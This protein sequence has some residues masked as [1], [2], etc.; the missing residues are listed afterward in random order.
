[1]HLVFVKVLAIASFLLALIFLIPNCL[2]QIQFY[3]IDVDLD[4]SGRSFVTLTITFAEIKDK[5]D[6]EVIG[7]VENL[8]ASSEFGTINCTSSGKGVSRISCDINISVG[9]TVKI[10][11]ETNDFVKVLE[12][13]YYFD[14][15]FT[16][17]QDIDRVSA[18]A[19]LP[20]GMALIEENL[21]ASRVSFPENA[22][23]SASGRRIIVIWRLEEIKANQPLKLQFLYEQIAEVQPISL[24]YFVILGVVIALVLIVAYIRFFKKPQKLVLSVLDE[25][26]RKVMD[27]IIASGGVINQKKVVEQTN[28]SKAKVSRVVK[29]LVERGLIEVESVGR[30]NKLK[31]VKKKLSF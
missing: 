3:G 4:R 17:G 7:R 28:L 27:A 21:S 22:S 18:F 6:F 12:N 20:E 19:K 29:S 23:T 26:E 14:G 16:L 2:A 10:S 1:M 9:R 15:D 31:L 25:F 8:K 30:T 13:K 11:F 24:R 5:L